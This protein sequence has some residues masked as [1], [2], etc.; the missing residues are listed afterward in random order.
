MAEMLISIFHENLHPLPIPKENASIILNQDPSGKTEILFNKST[1]AGIGIF[2]WSDPHNGHFQIS[3]F[4]IIHILAKSF[5]TSA[6]NTF[7]V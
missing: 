5:I 7:L 2:N 1:K 4:F 6:A 3:H